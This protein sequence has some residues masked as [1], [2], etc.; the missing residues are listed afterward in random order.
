MSFGPSLEEWQDFRSDLFDF[1]GNTAQQEVIWKRLVSRLQRF[2]E[3]SPV[4]E[5]IT[6][7]CLAAYNSFRVWPIN[8]Q[9]AFGTQD[10]EYLYILLNNDYLRALGLL[11]DQ[12][13]FTFNPFEDRFILNGIPHKVSGDTPAAQDLNSP[14]FTIIILERDLIQT[15][16]IQR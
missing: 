8:R 2:G 6:L 11:N 16:N 5:N 13:I 4:Y 10:K 12:S 15:A 9:S 1:A 3:D 7:K 14:I